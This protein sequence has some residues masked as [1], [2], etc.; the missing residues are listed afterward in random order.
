MAEP[1]KILTV[2]YG[3]FS[4]TLEGFDDAFDTMKAI[5]EYF[6]DL[7][8]DDR[9]FGAEPPTPDPEMLARI[10][11]RDIERRVEARMERGGYVL[12]P[13]ALAATGAT[14]TATAESPLSPAAPQSPEAQDED[15]ASTPVPTAPGAEADGTADPS[16]E[17]DAD[18]TDPDTEAMASAIAAAMPGAE[19]EAE[20]AE[21]DRP[22]ETDEADEPADAT[23]TETQTAPETSEDTAPAE[24]DDTEIA[25]QPEPEQAAEVTESEAAED[26]A[27]RE[28]A[29]ADES[30]VA[31][32]APKEAAETEPADEVDEALG[33]S[34][35]EDPAL[36]DDTGD[37]DETGADATEAEYAQTAA[38][39]DEDET[40]AGTTEAGAA[41]SAAAEADKRPWSEL[42]LA[43][44]RERRRL[45]RAQRAAAR[46][47]AA[48]RDE[49]TREEATDQP[50][51]PAE[52]AKEAAASVMPMPTAEDEHDSV[53]SKLA[54]IRAVVGR[55][56]PAAA[57]IDDDEDED[58]APPAAEMPRNAVLDSI[59]AQNDMLSEEPA[60]AAEDDHAEEASGT[61]DTA[62]AEPEAQETPEESSSAAPIRAR[63]VRMKRSEFEAQQAA[64]AEQD[65][66]ELGTTD[67]AEP[68]LETDD[69]ADQTDLARLDGI[70]DLEDHVVA[71]QEQDAPG[72]TLS[73]DDEA[74]LME[75]LAEVER[76]NTA[77]GAT[78][79][80]AATI[81]DDD[82]DEARV[83]E[84]TRPEAG[85]DAA[86]EAH[87]EDD[88]AIRRRNRAALLAGA[89]EADE[90]GMSRI[91][92]ETDA[93][94]QEPEGN[95]RREAIAHLKAAVAA[96]E[97]ARQLGEDD[98]TED[99]EN[100]F[101]ED[102][103]QVVRP[104]RTARP[105]VRSDRPRPAPLKLVASQRV[106]VPP[107][108]TARE[109][110]PVRPVMPR[111]V[112]TGAAEP[113][114]ENETDLSERFARF[115]ADTGAVGLS[116]MLEAAAAYA[117]FVEHEGDVSRPQIMKM[118]QSILPQ[119]FS[120]EDG[121]RAFGTLLR[122][123]RIQKVRNG[124]FQ[125][126]PQT[127]FKPQQAASGT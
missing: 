58:N 122:Q 38:D 103:E 72:S 104:R 69:E 51:E 85:A 114:Q 126:S 55:N 37:T 31:E 11:E 63:V 99:E 9:Y 75:E 117:A 101:R 100:M 124:R 15:V 73:E 68:L 108:E 91:L 10:A 87:A 62:P 56:A 12:R 57:D 105:V 65:A 19:A 66:Q 70:D 32:E 61:A 46:E 48:A 82:E 80:G 29:E 90:A 40:A 26:A 6:R 34:D 3:T 83:A 14:G 20:S 113:R 28:T 110:T 43:E 102:L 107:A 53:A 27:P 24:A 50:A 92:T 111:R 13:A 7:A 60:T 127:R 123:G 115:A 118:V 125:V 97:A 59:L 18:G 42:S 16:A 39:Q 88:P 47:E 4:C 35:A 77:D 25:E 98:G 23:E 17:A 119:A 106:D 120:R 74:D 36:S 30:V 84:A 45:R 1:S 21:D 89:P 64:E 33:G 41:E 94:L 67:V 49:P 8:A 95:R 109:S 116:D 93:Q 112:Q 22:T 121:L 5:A 44:R 96:T 78:G 71:G 2:S 54:R 79:A 76:L 81:D 52:P 86:E